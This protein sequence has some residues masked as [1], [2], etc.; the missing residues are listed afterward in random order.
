[1][2][3]DAVK[4]DVKHLSSNKTQKAEKIQLQLHF[5]CF[6]GFF[7]LYLMKQYVEE[8]KNT[9]A[10]ARAAVAVCLA[11]S[12]VCIISLLFQRKAFYLFSYAASA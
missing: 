9:P 1:M 10:F 3:T 12:K 11:H 5:K 2:N 6:P 7:N 8:K 4:G